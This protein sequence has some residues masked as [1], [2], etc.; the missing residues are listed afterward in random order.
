MSNPRCP[1][2]GDY[3][4]VPSPLSAGD[5]ECK[6][7]G[8]RGRV[9]T[10]HLSAAPAHPRR[11]ARRPSPIDVAAAKLTQSSAYGSYIIASSTGKAMQL[12]PNERRFWW[13]DK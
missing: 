10:F 6:A 1:E 9:F 4:V 2:C 11:V 5:N 7:C 12:G 8:H 13:Q 3:N